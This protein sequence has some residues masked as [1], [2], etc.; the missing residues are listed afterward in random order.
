VWVDYESLRLSLAFDLGT[1]ELD[2]NGMWID[3]GDFGS[4]S[5]ELDVPEL[6]QVP[7]DDAEEIPV[8]APAPAAA[9]AP[10]APPKMM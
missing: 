1:M 4:E 9:P 2:P 10:Q 8:P 3:R 5:R 7:A 6:R